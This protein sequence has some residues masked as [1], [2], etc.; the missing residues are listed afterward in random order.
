[1]MW[2]W[3]LAVVDETILHAS[4]TVEEG[5]ECLSAD[6]WLAGH[7]RQRYMPVLAPHKPLAP[8]VSAMRDNFRQAN[9]CRKNGKDH[10]P[11][12][13]FKKTAKAGE[14]DVD[15]SKAQTRLD[16]VAQA[17]ASLVPVQLL[18]QIKSRQRPRL[19]DDPSE[20]ERHMEWVSTFV[21]DTFGAY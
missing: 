3:L 6:F 15:L 7:L 1:M 20:G 12:R 8:T 2:A 17:A 11:L 4:G 14:V 13:R 21:E 16:E 19:V 5:G 18:V 10:K 9:L